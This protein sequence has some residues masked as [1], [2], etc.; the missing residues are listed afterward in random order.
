M[1]VLI[2]ISPSEYHHQQQAEAFDDHWRGGGSS[3]SIAMQLSLLKLRW[4]TTLNSISH[5]LTLATINAVS[6]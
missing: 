5:K 6:C 2:L 4:Q 3:N 1:D